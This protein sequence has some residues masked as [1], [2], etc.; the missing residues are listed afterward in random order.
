MTP[1][2][3]TQARV[4]VIGGGVVGCSV[5]YHL[6]K[7]GWTDVVLL[8]RKQLTSG[9]TWH[10]AGLIGQLRATRPMAQLAKYTADLYERL[11]EETGQSTGFRRNGSLT[12]ATDPERLEEL[13]RAVAM[14]GT[15]DL[16]AGIIGPAE[17]RR[18]WPALNTGDVL[19]ASFIPSDGQANPV[20]ITQA[21]AKGAR[22]GGAR[23]F[24]NTRVTGIRVEDGAVAGVSTEAGDIACQVAV[25]CAGMWGREV[26]LMAGVNVPLHAAE[27]FYVVTE[28]MEAMTPGLPVMRDPGN[29]AYYKEDAGKLLLGA[30]EPRAKPWGMD[31]IPDDFAFGQL[32]D[33]W[34]HFEPIL[35]KAMERLPALAEVG[36]QTFFN[37]PESFTPDN[38]YLLGEAPEV[39]NFFVA[40]GFNSIGIQSAGGAGMALAQW[41]A[42]GQAPMDLGDV[43]IRRMQPFHGD[44]DYLRR[45]TVEAV[46][47]LYAMHWPFRQFETARDVF[48]SPL[49]DRLGDRGACFGEAAGWERPNWFALDGVKP[50]YAYSWGRQNWFEASAAEHRAVR[51]AVGLFDQTSF[52]KFELTGPDAER[53]LGRVSAAEVA[54]A[55][56]RIVYTQW[57]NEKGGIEADLT[58]TRLAR[59]RYRIVTGSAARTRHF[60]WLKRHMGDHDARLADVTED[61]AVLGVFGPRARDLL[62]GLSGADLADDAFPFLAAREIEIGGV[63]V[64]A[65]RVTYVGELGWE[66]TVA[67]ADAVALY[68]ALTTAGGGL[69]LAD[70]GYH[71][72]ESLRLEKAYRHWGRDITD[73]E[74]PLEA[75]LGFAVAFDKPGGFIGRDAL[76][77]QRDGGVQKRLV[78]FV[79]GEE[80]P[81]LYHNEPIWRDGRRVGYLT[82][83]WYG[84]TLGAAV[85]LGYVENEGGVSREFIEAGSYEI[86]VAGRRVPATAHLRPAYDPAGGRVKGG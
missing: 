21:L 17:L 81:L 86:D 37:G 80:K 51:Q 44:A 70:A 65:G 58:V 28:P 72:M 33:D 30:F 40:A 18:L 53:L 9:T 6:T 36:I 55:P 14:A 78:Q 50:A 25:N 15:V 84:H 69:G 82:S 62:S 57:L 43:D 54:V 48:T 63:P 41:I 32:P 67:P 34:E 59:D 68:D 7:V 2:L 60:H 66:L 75:G 27:H 24:E 71:A 22:M 16:E 4:V 31:G 23:I 3:P 20:D 19:A 64:L 47:L 42:D 79:L 77:A 39:R 10:A 76:L 74:T 29:C 26:G 11:E 73:A 46:G 85:G 49:H 12:L 83:G 35:L 13:K 5:A 38:R 52:A 61:F 1:E 56:G 45:R 8:E